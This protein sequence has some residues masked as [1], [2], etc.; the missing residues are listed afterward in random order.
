MRTLELTCL[1]TVV[2]AT[3]GGGGDWACVHPC[4]RMALIAVVLHAAGM[5]GA[6]HCTAPAGGAWAMGCRTCA[7]ILCL[8]GLLSTWQPAPVHVT[9]TP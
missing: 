2:F 6:V 5:C 4:L 9:P 8:C 1:Y 3:D 7:V